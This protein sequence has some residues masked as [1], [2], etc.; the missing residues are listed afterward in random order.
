MGSTLGSVRTKTIKLVFVAS[1]V[2]K[3][4]KG[5]RA[6]TAWLRIEIMYPSGA[7]CLLADCCFSELAL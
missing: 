4:H 2:S 1:P 6:K 3:Q 5:E 7:T